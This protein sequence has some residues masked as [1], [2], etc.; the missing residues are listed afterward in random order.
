[1]K[2]CIRP[3]IGSIALLLAVGASLASAAEPAKVTYTEHVQAIFRQK[4][5]SCHNADKKE[6]GLDLSSFTALMAGGS[7]GEAIDPGNISGSYLWSLVTH[8]SEPKMPP[9]SE[10]LAAEQLAVISNWIEGGA[11][12][13]PNS[14]AL[15]SKKPK[16]DLKVGAST[17][18]PAGPPPMPLRLSLA[19]VVKTRL[20]TAIS[21]LAVSPWAPLAA[22]PGQKQVLLYDTKS[23]ELVGVLP[24][25][26]GTPQV[27][28]FSRNGQLLMAAGGKAGVSG[29]VIVWNVKTGERVFEVGDELDMILAADLSADQSLIALGGPAKVVRVYS[30][31]EGKL[32]WESK[33]HTDWI[34]S[35]QFSP[36][37]VLLATGDRNGGIFVWESETGREFHSLRAHTA[38][39]TGCSWR[40]DSNLLAS[41]SE[42]GQIR[43]W[44]ME[45]GASVKNWA[46]H[47]GGA[48]SVD[49]A[50]DGRL[51]SAGR[52]K[53]VKLW[54]QNGAQQRAFEALADISLAAAICNESSRILGGDW[55]GAVR[56]WNAADGAKVG[57]LTPNPATLEERLAA[58][59]AAL[60]A[61]QTEQKTAADAHAA[62]QV[63]ADKARADAA[64][65][66]QKMA[67]L[68]KNVADATAAI[69]KTKEAQAAA[70]TAHDTAAKA[71]AEL[72]PLVAPL[73]DAVTKTADPA[74]KA[75]DKE[76]AAAL[77]ALK[78]LTETRV[79]TLANHKKTV[80][81]KATEL[82]K[83]KEQLTALEAGVASNTAAIEALKPTLPALAAAE[84]A[85]AEKAAAAKA[86][87]DAAGA[88]LAQSQQSVAR[89]TSEIQFA[90][91]L[92]ALDELKAS[93]APKLSAAGEAQAALEQKRAEL[94]AAQSAAATGQQAIDVANTALVAARQTA[95]AA[96][97]AQQLA[98]ATVTGL[99][100]ALPALQDAHGKS[101]AAAAQTP[102]DATLASAAAALKS[103]LEK[104]QAS[105]A[106]SKAALA[107]KTA[108]AAKAQAAV[109]E[110]E[111]KATAAV[112]AR[113]AANAKVAELTKG[114]KPAEDQLAS[115]K[116]AADKAL[117]PVTALQLEIQKLRE[118]K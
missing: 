68:T 113:D 51:V 72:A 78:A 88:K 17:E 13:N 66:T 97:A 27:L 114:M 118:A 108:M 116:Q 15:A 2:R 43:L 47:S 56:L 54:D 16:V 86:A 12:D 39:V 64:A 24:F 62:A 34:T 117:E 98:A 92:K 91:R 58:A 14:K 83:A 37:S 30:T 38:A 100:S 85:A 76:V 23:L 6:G 67:E 32:V 73:T 106:A 101:A 94:A 112:A 22:V 57:E 107:E 20:T 77:A 104:H 109:V 81:E 89:W 40:L 33:K 25:P 8:T 61:V 44:E 7:S 42:D 41:A 80:A 9:K 115:A 35:L 36:D 74:A 93:V 110:G 90:G 28:R 18:R 102:A 29:K 95:A 26:E 69:A 1:M 96:V 11:L 79:Q 82:A 5:F 4:C 99:D 103:A 70:Q 111:Q 59:Q 55:T 10:K 84:K 46:A 52:D 63:M 49:F 45:N 105:V 31:S 87:A 48:A 50:R 53:I 71:A 3:I 19:P 60:P 21:S 75:D 65:A